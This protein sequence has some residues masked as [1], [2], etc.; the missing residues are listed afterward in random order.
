MVEQLLVDPWT[1]IRKLADTAAAWLLAWSPVLGP[2]LVLVVGAAVLLRAWWFRR[3]QQALHA[4]ARAVTI[5]APPTVDPAG[6]LAVW[7]NLVGLLRPA[8]K[9]LIFGQPHLAFESYFDRDGVQ[10]RLW[11]P[12][13]VPP[14]LVERA[15]EAAWPGTRTRTRPADPPLP[16]EP[17]GERQVLVTGGVLRLA[18]SEAL[19][20]RTDFTA[21]P[22]RALL[23][24]PA[25]LGTDDRAC[26]QVLARPATGR[27]V[28]R[29]RRLARHLRTGRSHHRIGRVFDLLTPRPAAQPSA[30]PQIDRHTA[31]AYAAQDRAIV[32][33]DRGSH[34]DTLIRYA[35]TTHLPRSAARKEYRRAAERI[36]GRA[37]AIASAFSTFTEHNY[38]RRLRLRQPLTVLA[39]RRF[40]RGDLL[41][42]LELAAIAHLPTDEAIPG[43]ARAGARAVPP[44]P[45][46][47]TEGPDIRPLGISDT[48]HA[49]PVGLHV[50]D[51]RHHLHVLGATGSGKSTLLAQMILADADRGRGAVVIDPK[52]DLITDILTR[53]PLHASHRVVLFDADTRGPVPCLNPL[54]GDKHSA[55]DN[56]VSVFARV[57]ASAWGPRSDDILRAA[58]LT[59]RA[60]TDTPTLA[61][62]S[63]L[64]TDPAKR[65]R[66]IAKLADDPVLRGFWTSYD[67]LSDAARAHA[68]APVLNKLRAFL[69]R[70]FVVKAIAAGPSTV[71]LSTVLDGGLLLARIP[72]G[73]LGDDTSRL[74]GSLILARI[75][76][77]TTARSATPQSQRRD[78]GLYVDEAQNFLTLPY[79]VEDMLAEA[80]G[81]RLSM[82]LAHQHLDQLG[83]DLSEAISANARTKIYFSVS[84]RDARE[85]ARHTAPHL[86]DHDLAHLDAFHAAVRPVVNG[87]EVRPFTI[88][89]RPLGPAIPGRARAVRAAAAAHTQPL[90]RSAVSPA[91]AVGAD[92]RRTA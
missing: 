38:Y 82:T 55:V 13:I 4:D 35:V 25:G 32:A 7:S 74:L 80:R 37:H 23:G 86:T 61:D 10:L 67:Q 41:S 89:T 18:R 16:I 27:R 50:S 75:W 22:L 49:R 20:I 65:I 21:D 34:Y 48:A 9:R 66:H 28:A 58:C 15:I 64:L 59:L 39:R 52:G 3:C 5:M 77:A 76:Q 31:L 90:A 14:G 11:V 44:P 73:S 45:A 26:V 72:K 12:G 17:S 36:R 19:P 83:R 62:L 68:I 57:F 30:Q 60:D 92:P 29:A 71:D 6:A 91:R 78:A 54:E 2:V 87:A 81:Y 8:W 1:A 84:P 24:A 79:A 53:L 56:V 42:V 40:R 47:P 63:G 46:T 43:V 88:T 70:P 85:L 33:K 51:A 69:L